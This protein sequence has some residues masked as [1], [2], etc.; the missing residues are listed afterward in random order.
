MGAGQHLDV[1]G[2]VGVPGHRPVMGPV[3]ADQLGQDVCV[4]GIALGAGDPVPFAVAGDLQWIDRVHGVAG[5]DQRLHARAAVGLD[6]DDHLV[7]LGV[8]IQMVS[9]QRM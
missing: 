9:D 8:L 7:G 5:R 4:A 6:A 3:Q 1:L 2:H